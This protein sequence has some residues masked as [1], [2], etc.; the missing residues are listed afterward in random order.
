MSRKPD[1]PENM[2]IEPFRGAVPT[3]DS[4]EPD[5]PYEAFFEP[6]IPREN[7]EFQHALAAS[8][9][10]RFREY[11][12]QLQLP[13][14]RNKKCSTIAKI[15]EIS[16]AEFTDFLRNASRTRA[17]SIAAARLPEITMHMADDA[18][19]QKATCGR[20]DG[21]GFVNI[22]PEEMPSLE[23]GKPIPGGIRPMGQR[24]VRDCPNCDSTGKTKKPG[25]AHARDKILLMN[26]IGAKSNGVT[27][28]I[29]NNYG[30]NGIESAGARLAAITFDV[31][32][33]AVIEGGGH[34][35]TVDELGHIIDGDPVDGVL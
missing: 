8:S 17:I 30:G 9:D 21:W 28:A 11:L 23:D 24:W 35:S 29:N 5:L 20:C 31:S 32:S 3:W 26:G 19:T 34:E 2:M 33:E 1:L 6:I 15:M 12:R 27:V 18:L 7:P 16:L 22:T 14:N 10:K 13:K 4:D 25:D